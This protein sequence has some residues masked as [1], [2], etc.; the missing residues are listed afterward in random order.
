V[1]K[2]R[3]GFCIFCRKNSFQGLEANG[4]DLQI[5]DIAFFSKNLRKILGNDDRISD[6]IDFK[7]LN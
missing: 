5:L 2:E 7:L 3:Q 1:E 4:A 6:M